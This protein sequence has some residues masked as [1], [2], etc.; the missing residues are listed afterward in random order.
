MPGKNSSHCSKERRASVRRRPV[1]ER[2]MNSEPLRRLAAS[3]EPVVELMFLD[4]LLEREGDPL[5]NADL[6][7]IVEAVVFAASRE[8]FIGNVPSSEMHH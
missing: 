3:L 2:K 4:N 5:V 1:V 6:M 7:W 8:N